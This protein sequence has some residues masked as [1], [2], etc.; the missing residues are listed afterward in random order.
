M[1]NSC[2]NINVFADKIAQHLDSYDSGG[3]FLSAIK[4]D[5]VSCFLCQY[6]R[7]DFILDFDATCSGSFDC[8]LSGESRITFESIAG[9]LDFITLVESKRQKSAYPAITL[10]KMPGTVL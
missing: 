5:E 3:L 1:E 7:D 6:K 8:D 10:G 4:I 2:S 9:A